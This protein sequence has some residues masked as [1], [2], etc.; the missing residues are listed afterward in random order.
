MGRIII[1]LL[2]LCYTASA[3]VSR[4]ADTLIV[5]TSKYT[6]T[7]DLLTLY[8]QPRT[9]SDF[10]QAYSDVATNSLTS[11][12][13]AFVR[14]ALIRE[15]TLD[16]DA[17]GDG[18]VDPHRSDGRRDWHVNRTDILQVVEN[19]FWACTGV[20]PEGWP[21]AAEEFHGRING[22]AYDAV[23]SIGYRVYL[24]D[25]FWNADNIMGR[26]DY[27]MS[28]R[29]A[30]FYHEMGHALL[31]LD[32][33]CRNSE[34]MATASENG[35]RGSSGGAIGVPF[36]YNSWQDR[37]TRMFESSYFLAGSS[38]GSSSKTS[39]SKSQTVIYD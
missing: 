7:G 3:Q 18:Y 30:L 31:D 25:P 23:S 21:C 11:Y 36:F 29:M 24:A 38:R 4:D 32:H 17:D 28:T 1:L 5:G 13:K 14:D 20:N 26:D 27:S 22:A 9:G 6:M 33:V 10:S 19:F 16:I 37:V 34:I 39:S 15:A 35:C 8:S 12:L 2:M